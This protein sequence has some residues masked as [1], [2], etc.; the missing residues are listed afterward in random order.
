MAFN[1]VG[2]HQRVPDAF[3]NI[4]NFFKSGGLGDV[5][6]F[7]CASGLLKAMAGITKIMLVYP[8]LCIN[9]EQD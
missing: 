7:F 5:L 3:A 4:G 2:T 8:I 6:Q 1:P 9:Q